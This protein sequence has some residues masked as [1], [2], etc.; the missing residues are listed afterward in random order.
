MRRAEGMPETGVLSQSEL[1]PAIRQEIP[2]M[3]ISVHAYSARP[4]DRMV[5]INDRLL[6]EGGALPPGLTLDEITPEG[7]IFSYKGYRFKRGLSELGV[8]AGSR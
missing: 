6:R 5:G 7:M 2:A 1:P 4:Q 3:S 8:A